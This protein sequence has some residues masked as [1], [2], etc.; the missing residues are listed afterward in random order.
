MKILFFSAQNEFTAITS[1]TLQYISY[2]KSLRLDT[3]FCIAAWQK[4]FLDGRNTVLETRLEAP[5]HVWG[6]DLTRIRKQD[7]HLKA[8]ELLY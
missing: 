4:A 8:K 2:L 7:D 3:V 6:Q 1:M 5:E